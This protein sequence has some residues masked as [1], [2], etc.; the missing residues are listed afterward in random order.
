[1]KPGEKKKEPKNLIVYWS[2]NFVEGGFGCA[3]SGGSV[4]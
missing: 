2:I 1:M 3:G 4:T